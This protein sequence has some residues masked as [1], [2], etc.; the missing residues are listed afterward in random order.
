MDFLQLLAL[1]L[2]GKVLYLQKSTSAVLKELLQH[3]LG[4]REDSVLIEVI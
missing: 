4:M 3:R 2:V 1:G